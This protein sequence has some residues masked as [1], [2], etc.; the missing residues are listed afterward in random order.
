MAGTFEKY[1]FESQIESKTAE[2]DIMSENAYD[3]LL[4]LC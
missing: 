2:F 4:F 3:K 1:F